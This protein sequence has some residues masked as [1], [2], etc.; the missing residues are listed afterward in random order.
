ML[1]S[2]ATVNIPE[3]LIWSGF[4]GFLRA[5]SGTN[6]TKLFGFVKNFLPRERFA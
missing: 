1:S 5:K 2:A 4:A 6:I 3:T